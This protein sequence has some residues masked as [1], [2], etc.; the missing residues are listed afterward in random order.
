MIRIGAVSPPSIR[1]CLAALPDALTALAFLMCWIAPGLLGHGWVATLMLAVLVEFIVIHA[2]GFL[3]SVALADRG[4][5]RRTLILLG[6]G[7]PYLLLIL[8]VCLSIE[9]WWPL[10]AFAWLFLAKIWMIWVDDKPDALERQRQRELWAVSIIAYLGLAFVVW[11]LW[12]PA[13]GINAA[14]RT[15]LPIAAGSVWRNNAHEVI[16]FGFAYYATLALAKAA[17]LPRPAWFGWIGSA[18]PG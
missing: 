10:A 5:A 6:F 16:A 4:R 7:L 11:A 15:E 18:D 2:T 13:F 8:A 9:A 1:Q 14:V 12:V 3:F 17:V